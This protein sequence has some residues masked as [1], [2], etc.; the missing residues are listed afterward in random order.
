[1]TRGEHNEA[2][3][4][5]VSW[6]GENGR[7][8]GSLPGWYVIRVCPCHWGERVTLPQASEAEAARVR[9]VILGE[10]PARHWNQPR[11]WPP[12]P[13][14]P[15]MV[16]PG[17]V[18]RRNRLRDGRYFLVIEVRQGRVE[19]VTVARAGG[20]WVAVQQIRRRVALRRL[21]VRPRPGAP[22]PYSCVEEVADPPQTRSQK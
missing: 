19:V 13:P 2:Q 3:W 15:A 6:Q 14:R 10:E 4:L 18:W 1:M 20:G 17:Q 8:H 5:A 16:L 21:L 22:W 11:E 9:R 12:D 7:G